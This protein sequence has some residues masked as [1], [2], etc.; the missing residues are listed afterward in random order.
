MDV[1]VKRAE[2]WIRPLSSATTVK[3]MR[4]YTSTPTYVFKS[5][6]FKHKGNKIQLI[7]KSRAQL[8]LG[9][10]TVF[11][12][13]R[14]DVEVKIHASSTS[15]LDCERPA[16]FPRHV[17]YCERRWAPTS[18]DA[19]RLTQP[20]SATEWICL[21]NDNRQMY[22][23]RLLKSSQPLNRNEYQGRLLAVKTAGA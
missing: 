11:L 1:G 10:F 23:V 9:S 13:C 14:G 15:A 2:A 12:P 22:T 7:V 17:C 3:N 16:T 21:S 5:L 19:G 4:S 18:Y 8:S 6:R 20:L